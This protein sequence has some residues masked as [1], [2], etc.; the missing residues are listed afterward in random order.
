MS[1]F[2][3]VIIILVISLIVFAAKKLKKNDTNLLSDT[4]EKPLKAANSWGT[5]HLTQSFP[6]ASPDDKPQYVVISLAADGKPIDYDS[7][8]K[9][10]ENWP[11]MMSISYLIFDREG[12]LN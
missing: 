2:T 11:E 5:K 9:D 7:P 3:V 12:Y 6:A 8:A 4:D 10:L 1:T